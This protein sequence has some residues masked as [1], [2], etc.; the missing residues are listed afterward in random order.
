M[1]I[2]EP[3]A[4]LVNPF[5]IEVPLLRDHFSFAL[6]PITT[7]RA[8]L[9]RRRIGAVAL[10]LATLSPLAAC[11]SDEAA[12]GTTRVNVVAFQPPSLGAFLPAV[13]EDRNIDNENGLDLQ[14][15]YATPDAYNSE[16]GAGHY[17]VGAS[18]ALLSEGLRTERGSEVTYLFN[19]FDFFGTVV[20]QEEAIQELP[21]LEGRTLAAATGTTNFAMFG[22][23]AEQAGLE[24]SKVETLNQ[25]PSGLSTMA[26]TG[27][28]DAVELWEP[29]YSTLVAQNEDIRTVGLDF[30]AWEEE[31]GTDQ[32]PY[33]GL[34]AQ[35]DWA[36]S[37]PDEVQALYD[38]YKAAADWALENPEDAAGIIAAEIPGG[39]PAVVQDLI[40]NN[41]ERLRMNVQP[42]SAVADGI[43]SVFQAG[44]QTGYLKK[45]PPQSVIYDGLK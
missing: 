3:I 4:D 43:R 30:A 12:E 45:E 11:G 26:Q 1:Q 20:T 33:L 15:T 35:R 8:R 5:R 24:L 28:T 32:I 2:A 6:V 16:F 10:A 21:D 14:F 7:A 41:D 34:A 18:A 39:D 17:D 27:R 37:H 25:T 40:Q 42:A 38:T 22:W 29:A 19:L 36:E 23:F 9:P 13:I 31:F 44:Q